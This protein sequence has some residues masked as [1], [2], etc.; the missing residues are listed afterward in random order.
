MP[1]R[2]TEPMLERMQFVVAVESGE[3]SFAEACRRFSI[4]RKTGYKWWDRYEQDGAQALVDRARIPRCCP[5]ALDEVTVVAILDCKHRHGHWGPRKLRDYLVRAVPERRWPAVSTFGEVLARHGLV[6]PRRRRVHVPPQ[7][8]P[9][10]HC[11]AANEVWSVDFKGQFRLGN[12]HWCY[13]FTLSDNHSRYL[14]ACRALPR[15]TEELVRA[16]CENIFRDHGLPR[17]IRSDNGAPFASRALG[18]LTRLSVWWMKLGIRPERIAP[19]APQQ[20]GRHERMH[21]TLKAETTGPA[22]FSLPTQQRRFNAFRQE[23]NEERPHEALNGQPPALLYRPSR[24]PYPPR[25]PTIEYD[26]GTTVR[27]VRTNG[28]IKWQGE[29]YFVSEVLTGELVG[30][31]PIDSDRWQIRFAEL[32]LAILDQRSGQIIRPV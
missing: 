7:S 26:L 3:F 31:T 32:P 24:C 9:L 18:G 15:P 28:T 13:P 12:G 21:R 8:T 29:L 16:Q 1:W 14:L 6:K 23:Y 17:A 22:A 20:N 27:R 4:S 2:R 19:G 10:A 11:Q 30:L 5:H 25:L